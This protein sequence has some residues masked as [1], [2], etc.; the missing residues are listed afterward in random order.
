MTLHALLRREF[1]LQVGMDC[2]AVR[3]PVEPQA[4]S[5]VRVIA[6]NKVHQAGS[7]EALSEPQDQLVRFVPFC[8]E[9]MINKLPCSQCVGFCLTPCDFS[10][11][12]AD[13]WRPRVSCARSRENM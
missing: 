5:V 4:L 11:T 1:H 12:L 13:L 6:E 2:L 7:M 3:V 8:K 9:I 10:F